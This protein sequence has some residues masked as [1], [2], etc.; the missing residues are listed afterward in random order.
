MGLY[1]DPIHVNIVLKAVSGTAVL[2]ESSSNLILLSSYSSMCAKLRTD[3]MTGDDTTAINS[4]S[5]SDPSPNG[6]SN[7]LVTRAQA[8]AIGAIHDDSHVDGTFTFGAGFTYTFDPNNRNGGGVRGVFD[9]I[10]IALHEITEIMGRIEGLGTTFGLG[11]PGYLLYD[12]F[13]YQGPG[14]LDMTAG[15]NIYFSIDGG[16]VLAKEYN[17]PNGD[18]SDPQ[19]WASGFGADACNAFVSSGN[20][21]VFSEVD[22]QVMD[23]IGYD[24][25]SLANRREAVA[26]GYRV[27][28]TPSPLMGVPLETIATARV[29]VKTEGEQRAIP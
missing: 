18:G 10:G 7:W 13:R 1:A 12:L 15:N 5:L 26:K 6:A 17:Y 23:V 27:R 8:K 14:Q 19:D 11:K 9:Y 24:R 22:K 29:H 16:T 21:L 20:E 28:E 3:A 25:V 2:G 4:L